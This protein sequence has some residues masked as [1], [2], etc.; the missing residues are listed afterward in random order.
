LR[1]AVG[2]TPT[3]DP[4]EPLPIAAGA[5][6]ASLDNVTALSSDERARLIEGAASMPHQGTLQVAHSLLVLCEMQSGVSNK[7]RR[8][9]EQVSAA[10][11]LQELDQ[12]PSSNHLATGADDMQSSTGLVDKLLY[13]DSAVKPVVYQGGKDQSFGGPGSSAMPLPP[14]GHDS[15]LPGDNAKSTAY[16][17]ASPIRLKV[18]MPEDRLILAFRCSFA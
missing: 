7:M 18:K 17:V 1:K 13:A 2:A 4:T 3:K 5:Q 16:K 14:P 15:L 8:K 6:L 10:Q 12:A 9:Q 11:R